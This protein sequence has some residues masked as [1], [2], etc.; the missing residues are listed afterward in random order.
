MFFHPYLPPPEPRGDRRMSVPVR[1]GGCRRYVVVR[2]PVVPRQWRRMVYCRRPHGVESV[3]RHPPM[4]LPLDPLYS[5][6]GGMVLWYSLSR[7][8]GPTMPRLGLG[9]KGRSFTPAG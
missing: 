3:R 1:R 9:A 6:D 8:P 2:H 7:R 4:T 5:L